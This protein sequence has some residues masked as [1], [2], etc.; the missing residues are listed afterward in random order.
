MLLQMFL[1]MQVL[2]GC[3][4]VFAVAHGLLLVFAGVR[5]CCWQAVGAGIPL[6]LQLL[7]LHLL[8]SLGTQF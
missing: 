7:S 2:L 3:I 4:C 1:E 8:F 6:F 5:T